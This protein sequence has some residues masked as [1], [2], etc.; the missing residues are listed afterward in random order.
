MY[1]KEKICN[2]NITMVMKLFN[3]VSLSLKNNKK[4]GDVAQT[5]R[6]VA[7]ERIPDHRR[8]T[9]IRTGNLSDARYGK[10]VEGAGNTFQFIHV[11]GQ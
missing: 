2:K 10:K 7:R 9:G 5:T 6:S 1:R 4:E 8:R 11:T 3:V